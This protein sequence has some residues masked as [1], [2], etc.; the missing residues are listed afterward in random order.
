MAKHKN[1]PGIPLPNGWR[2]RPVAWIAAD[3]PRDE[4][5]R[6]S[7]HRPRSEP[8]NAPSPRSPVSD[9]TAQLSCPWRSEN[10]R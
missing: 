1:L 5:V 3:C 6:S 4:R 7:P 8:F 10:P 9:T 2:R